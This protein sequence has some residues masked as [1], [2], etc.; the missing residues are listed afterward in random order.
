MKKNILTIIILALGVI[1]LVLTAV[2]I[3][4][5]VPSANRTN[6]LINQV[7]SIIDL[8]LESVEEEE[9]ISPTDLQ[10]Y[11][12]AS[13]NGTL[14]LNLTA[15]A[16]GKE[17]WGQLDSVTLYMNTKADDYAKLSATL[18]TKKNKI[19]EIVRD[20]INSYTYENAKS[21]REKIKSQVLKAVQ[22]DF[23]SKFIVDLTFDNLR[24]Q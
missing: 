2:V 21:G 22:E 6:N 12:I 1:N 15:S 17:H 11:Q 19:L 14:T 8:E 13:E 16:D 24:F 18:E 10:S 9:K 7:S 3:F 5:C 23:D 20:V 4:V